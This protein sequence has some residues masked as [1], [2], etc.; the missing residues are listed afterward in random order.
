M[1]RLKYTTEGKSNKLV[2]DAYKLLR[3][4]DGTVP[5]QHVLMFC[6]AIEGMPSLSTEES[7]L[8]RDHF[9][10]FATVRKIQRQYG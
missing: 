10:E 3:N 8:W 6:F 1:Q 2:Q 9:R 5:S 7:Q 4:E